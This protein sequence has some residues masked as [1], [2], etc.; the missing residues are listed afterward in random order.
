MHAKGEST[1]DVDSSSEIKY[2]IEGRTA[3]NLPSTDGELNVSRIESDGRPK[4]RYTPEEERKVLLK[5]DL[6]LLPITTVLFTLSYLDRVSTSDIE[7]TKCNYLINATHAIWQSNIGNAKIEGLV[8]GLN[9][10]DYPTL[11]GESPSSS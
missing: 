9:I 2:D 8:E 6:V 11:T 10:K 4:V 5:T 3:P 1:N 7:A